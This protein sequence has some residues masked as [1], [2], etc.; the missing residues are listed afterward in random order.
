MKT[1][2]IILFVFGIAEVVSNFFHLLKGSKIKIGA[3]ARKQHQELPADTQDIDFFYKAII[4]FVIGLLYVLSSTSYFL[5]DTRT[6]IGFIWVNSII[7]SVYALIQLII[8]YR[9]YKVWT[10]FIVY[11]IPL[12]ICFWIG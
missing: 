2:I 1:F 4:M 12:L 5:L 7:M 6:G 10:S 8:Y 3:S 11:S 9:T